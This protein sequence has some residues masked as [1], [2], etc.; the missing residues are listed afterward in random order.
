MVR[1]FSKKFPEKLKKPQKKAKGKTTKSIELKSYRDALKEVEK[2]E[3]EIYGSLSSLLKE[4]LIEYQ[5]TWEVERDRLAEFDKFERFKQVF[6]T[7]LAKKAFK[8]R[9]KN[10]KNLYKGTIVAG[11]RV[12]I[13]LALFAI[14]SSPAQLGRNWDELMERVE[15]ANNFKDWFINL[16]GY[17]A[18]E[19][20]F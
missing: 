5:V 3:S 18:Q 12:Y 7:D 9:L 1:K 11:Y 6:G 8:E 19:N 16:E 13:E 17:D 2:R 20:E 14:V 15:V 10:L 4:E